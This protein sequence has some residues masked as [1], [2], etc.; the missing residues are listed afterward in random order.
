M[1]I[2][3]ELKITFNVEYLNYKLFSNDLKLDLI[4]GYIKDR[5]I[6]YKYHSN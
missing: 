4:N 3:V 5:V 6:I 2:E 1:I